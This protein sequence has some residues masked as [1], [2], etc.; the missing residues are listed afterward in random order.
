MSL[1]IVAPF[2]IRLARK[3]GSESKAVIGDG[4]MISVRFLTMPIL[5]QYLPNEYGICRWVDVEIIDIRR[6][7]NEQI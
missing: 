1:D 7:E 2:T 5:Q 4:E 3:I 6:G